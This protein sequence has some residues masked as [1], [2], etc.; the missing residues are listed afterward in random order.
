[1]ETPYVCTF[2]VMK[3]LMAII[4]RIEIT[5]NYN[6][7]WKFFQRRKFNWGLRVVSKTNLGGK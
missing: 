3:I 1:M 7:V 2:V 6:F 5:I 4:E